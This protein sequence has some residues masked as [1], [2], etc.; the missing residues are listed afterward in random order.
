MGNLVS[1][2]LA[3]TLARGRGL[4]LALALPLAG[5]LLAAPAGPAL[6]TTYTVA[7]HFQDQLNC[8]VFDLNCAATALQFDAEDQVWQREVA[9]AAGSYQYIVAKDGDLAY[10]WGS[11]GN[12]QAGPLAVPT[13]QIVKFYFD[14]QTH[15]V[16]DNVNNTIAVLAGDFQDELGCGSDW[17]PDCLRSWLKDQDG[18]GIYSFWTDLLPAGDYAAKIALDES[19]LHN[20]GAGGQLNGDLIHFTVGDA[21]VGFSWNSVT[22]VLEIDTG[23]AAAAPEPSAWILLIAGFGLAGAA[24]RA[25]YRNRSAQASTGSRASAAVE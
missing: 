6:A 11:P 4:A 13:D 2:A 7:G 18:D 15:W 1:A 16:A 5:G 25:A 19:W 8:S 20:Y 21:P 22:H 10:S 3:A 17:R 24:L 9:I 23:P 12:N 14:E